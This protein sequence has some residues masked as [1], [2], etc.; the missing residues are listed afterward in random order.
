MG[1]FVRLDGS[2]RDALL[3]GLG[4][5]AAGSEGAGAMAPPPPSS[6]HPAYRREREGGEG[7]GEGG[8]TAAAAAAAADDG[9]G[10]GG[11]GSEVYL[12]FLPGLQG[13]CWALSTQRWADELG[14]LEMVCSAPGAADPTAVDYERRPFKVGVRVWGARAWGC[15]GVRV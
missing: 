5:G 15:E 9:D 14:G 3:R 12:Y 6:L 1:T 2:R 8:A 7:E 4:G 11:G 10:G 13:G